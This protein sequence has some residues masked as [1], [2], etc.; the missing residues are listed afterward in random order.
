MLHYVLIHKAVSVAFYDFLGPDPTK[1]KINITHGQCWHAWYI[2]I[3]TNSTYE[4][5][6]DN[7]E[8][9]RW[10]WRTGVGKSTPT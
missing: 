6:R 10:S 2:Q 1:I 8:L 3:S 5:M 9:M 7:S 4:S